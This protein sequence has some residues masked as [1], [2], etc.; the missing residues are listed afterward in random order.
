MNYC[1]TKKILE[2]F[3]TK[4]IKENPFTALN[5]YIYIKNKNLLSL[6][7]SKE[8]WANEYYLIYNS[9]NIEQK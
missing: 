1:K 6:K 3:S 8:E 7:E 9:D 5:N 4:K 2:L